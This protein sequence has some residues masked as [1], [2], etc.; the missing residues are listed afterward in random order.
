M[1]IYFI[2]LPARVFVL[3]AYFA[4]GIVVGVTWFLRFLIFGYP[5]PKM[6]KC[7]VPVLKIHTHTRRNFALSINSFFNGSRESILQGRLNHNNHRPNT[8]ELSKRSPKRANQPNSSFCSAFTN[9]CVRRSISFVPFVT[10]KSIVGI[11][12][13]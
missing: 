8:N 13:K 10:Q 6:Y 2:Y 11:T 4:I 5:K 12:K 9:S 7:I 3:C 1:Y